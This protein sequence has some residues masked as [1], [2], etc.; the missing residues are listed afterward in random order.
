MDQYP[1]PPP[2]ENQT[3]ET[4]ETPPAASETSARAHV[5]GKSV[6]VALAAVVGLA[7]A[8][9]ATAFVT[10][11]GADERLL[12]KVPASAD[13]MIT[14]YLDPAAEQKM[15]LFRLADRLPAL[16]SGED[17]TSR[18]RQAVDDMLGGTGLS[19]DDFDWIGSQAAVAMRLPGSGTEAPTFAVLIDTDDEG[20][21]VDTFETLRSQD[22]GEWVRSE[23]AGV[24]VWTGARG[25][26]DAGAYAFVDGVAVVS[27]DAAMLEEVIDVAQGAGEAMVDDPD[28]IDTVGGLPDGKLAM[29]YASTRNIASQLEQLSGLA[30]PSV[31]ESLNALRAV[32][33]AAISVSAEPDGVAMDIEVTIDPSQLTKTQRATLAAADHENPLTEAIP[34]DAVVV[35]TQQGID[36]QL[37]AALEQL[38]QLDP[39]LASTLKK[40][41][42]IGPGGAIDDLT[43][44]IALAGLPRSEAGTPTGVLLVGSD[45]PEALAAA[46][47]SLIA[48]ASEGTG[49][50]RWVTETHQGVEITTLDDPS[51]APFAPSYAVIDGAGVVGYTT[52]AVRAVIDARTGSSIARIVRLHRRDGPGATGRVHAV[53][54]HRRHRRRDPRQPPTPA[55]GRV[56]GSRG[57]DGST[58]RVRGRRRAILGGRARTDVP[59]FR[60]TARGRVLVVIAARRHDRRTP[61]GQERS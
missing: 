40:S 2:P 52:D 34:Q 19:S 47:S 55:D 59:A 21:A 51:L 30:L 26:F 11:R 27:N 5:L 38:S 44:D 18:V 39:E 37:E 42:L 23:H 57:D 4:P 48:A 9:G 56:R 8:A 13:A 60:L 10:M 49:G 14:V 12:D 53:R 16:G 20:A 25:A 58:R 61:S 41:G 36:Q 6:L 22:D 7:V 50:L 29:A 54:R 46:A 3:P 32:R 45:D 15:N 31:G 17:M 28:F 1:P 35:L 43:G 24:E 33:G